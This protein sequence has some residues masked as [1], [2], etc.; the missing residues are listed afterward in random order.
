M[1]WWN[2][3]YLNTEEMEPEK[4]KETANM[5]VSRINVELI[6]KQLKT[7]VGKEL[8]DAVFT[9]LGVLAMPRRA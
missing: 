5:A 6:Y 3:I 4:Y 1:F 7:L 2:L 8:L 9:G